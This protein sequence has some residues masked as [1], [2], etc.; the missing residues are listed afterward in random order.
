M[1]GN[2]QQLVIMIQVWAPATIEVDEE[3]IGI[4]RELE[5]PIDKAA[6]ELIVLELYRLGRVSSG[7]AASILRM[8][9]KDFIQHASD[10]GIPYL[11]LT[12]EDLDSEIQTGRSL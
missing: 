4:L 2:P 9:R 3:L 11:R 7:R 8:S 12:A 6:T 5:Q 1:S 10:L